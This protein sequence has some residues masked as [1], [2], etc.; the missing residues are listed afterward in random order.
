MKL[1]LRE[2]YLTSFYRHQLLDQLWTFSQGTS[3]V[4][5]YYSRFVEHQLR[6]ALQQELV[7]TVSRFIHGLM[8]DHKHEV[9][10]SRPDVL[11]DTYCQA[12]DAET[13]LPPQHSGY[14][15]PPNNKGPTISTNA[16]I[17]CF[18]SNFNYQRSR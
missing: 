6:Y 7:V 17:E 5:D 12:L 10:R 16:R 14:P 13:Y 3:I 18:N 4:Q 1:K 2:L 8:D 9:S 11:E 15:A